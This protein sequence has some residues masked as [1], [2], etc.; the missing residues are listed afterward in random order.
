MR[1]SDDCSSFPE[2]GKIGEAV[3]TDVLSS[4]VATAFYWY[5][6]SKR[7]VSLKAGQIHMVGHLPLAMRKCGRYSLVR[8]LL[9]NAILGLQWLSDLIG[10]T[11]H[12]AF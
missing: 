9:S 5:M 12:D 8:D 1:L 4:K 2:H 7:A 3:A 10:Q 11:T 6:K